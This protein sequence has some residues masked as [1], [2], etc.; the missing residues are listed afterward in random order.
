MDSLDGRS[1][2]HLIHLLGLGDEMGEGSLEAKKGAVRC[3]PCSQNAHDE[4]DG[5]TPTLVLC[6]RN[7]RPQKNGK[8]SLVVLLLAER[9]RSECA[10]STR[11]IEDRPGHPFKREASE[12]GRNGRG[13]TRWSPVL[14]QRAVSEDPRWTRAVGDQ[15][16]P[17]SR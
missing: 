3:R 16:S 7:A 15:S 6:S 13:Q 14:V 10:R 4:G 17:P 8:G 5:R 12:L 9:A 2:T 1:R 11:A